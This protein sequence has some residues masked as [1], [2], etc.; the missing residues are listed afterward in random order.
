MVASRNFSNAPKNSVFCS[1]SVCIFGTTATINRYDL[2]AR[3]SQ[4]D[5]QD[6]FRRFRA[7]T[8][9]FWLSTVLKQMH[10]LRAY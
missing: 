8:V 4:H 6:A 7:D 9:S 3:S 10:R 5:C 2:T 1:L